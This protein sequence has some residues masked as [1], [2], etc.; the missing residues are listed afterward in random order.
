MD[1]ISQIREKIDIVALISEYLPLK[2]MGRNFKRT[3]PFHNEKTPSF[4]VSPERQIWHCFGCNR[5]GDAFTFLMEYENLEFPEALRILAKKAGVELVTSRFETG[6]SSQKETIYRM[7]RLAAEFYHYLLVKHNVGR[8]A[9]QYLAEERKIKPQVI[10]TFTLGFSPNVGN[11]LSQYLQQKKGFSKKDLLVSGL[12]FERQA[13]VMDFFAGR[14]MFPLFDHRDNVIGFSGRIFGPS[15]NSGLNSS[16]YVNTRE[17]L[18]YHKGS[19]FFGLNIAKQDIKK[20]DK[21]I[22]MEGEF[23]V[24]SSFQEGVRNVV[25]VKGTA[26]TESQVNLLSRFTSKISLCFDK[27]SAGQEAVKRSIPILEKKGIAITLVDIPAGKDPDEL[28]HQNSTELKKAVK[29]EIGIYD[30]LFSQSFSHFDKTT[31]NGKKNISDELLPFF[32]AIENEIIKEHYLKKLSQ[33]L[34]ISYES[35]I[36]QIEKLQKRSDKSLDSVKRDKKSRRE[37]L[38]QYLVSI[39][40]QNKET[41]ELVKK[42]AKALA[43]FKFQTPSYQRIFSLLVDYINHNSMFN[44]SSFAKTLQKELIEAFDI[45]FL[46]P[47]PKN[48]DQEKIIEEIDRVVND[49]VSLD[50]HARIK[51][52]TDKIKEKEN[53]Q[54]LEDIEALQQE[55]S[56]LVLLLPKSF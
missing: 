3:C 41:G 37:L 8:K 30:F 10:E 21:A 7:N 6:I 13:E 4:V 56:R 12:S 46:L 34:D 16:K 19:T 39:L 26:L 49:L 2:Q 28:V 14:I 29:N 24:M 53:R 20:E 27:D 51:G 42:T 1:H 43:N 44:S 9:Y 33:G 47:L 32:S 15:T 48:L 5:G 17:T 22:I 50:I 23:D 54:E 31:A 25:A 55:L 40:V 11:K 18:V 52:L 35:I 45:C 38:E 36:K